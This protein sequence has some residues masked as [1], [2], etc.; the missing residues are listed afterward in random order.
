MAK[1]KTIKA[2]EP[3]EIVE[4][5]RVA[6]TATGMFKS[7]RVEV[8]VNPVTPMTMLQ[9]MLPTKQPTL[10]E[11][12]AGIEQAVATFFTTKPPEHLRQHADE[13]LRMARSVRV[14]SENGDHDFAAVKA[15][16][17]GKAVMALMLRDNYEETVDTAKAAREGRGA[18]LRKHPKESVEAAVAAFNTALAEKPNTK[19]TALQRRVAKQYGIS[20]RTLRRHL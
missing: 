19:R 10:A 11:E 18:K 5:V 14:S 15:I 1:R 12:L 17:L 2:T 20:E 16:R 3:E 7:R 13:V 6:D 4:G 9:A 8:D